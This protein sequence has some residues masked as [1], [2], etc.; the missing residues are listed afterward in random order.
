VY[1]ETICPACGEPI[2]PE[3]AINYRKITTISDTRIVVK[4]VEVRETMTLEEL[5]QN[6]IITVEPLIKK[7]IGV[8]DLRE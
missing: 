6:I 1:I 7:G 3:V 5:V 4:N 2:A 8:Q